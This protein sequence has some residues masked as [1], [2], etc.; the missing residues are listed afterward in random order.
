MRKRRLKYLKNLEEDDE[1]IVGIYIG[2]YFSCISGLINFNV[3]II[4][5]EIGDN[6]TPSVLYIE[7]DKNILVGKEALKK[8][9]DPKKI[10]YDFIKLLEDFRDKH[11]QEFI[12]L[13]LQY[14]VKN[15]NEKPFIEIE[16][17]ENK[18]YFRKRQYFLYL[19]ILMIIK[20]I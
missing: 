16:N 4:P 11:T 8:S 18:Y 1:I 13:C 12:R 15:K 19:F 9:N 10:I 5:N 14:Q 6:I 17:N 3:E 20:K 7:D 2:W